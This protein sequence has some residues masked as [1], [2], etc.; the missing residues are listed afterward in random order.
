V[1][2]A[3][4]IG[5]KSFQPRPERTPAHQ[6]AQTL[7]ETTA[8]RNGVTASR[9][10]GAIGG[11]GVLGCFLGETTTTDETAITIPSQRSH[12]VLMEC[13]AFL[14]TIPGEKLSEDTVF[15]LVRVA[16]YLRQSQLVSNSKTPQRF[17][18]SRWQSMRFGHAMRQQSV[19]AS[20]FCLIVRPVLST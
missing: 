2:I 10:S 17:E 14:K 15:R 3:T 19:F 11:D 20:I 1:T 16:D 13:K 12:A 5:R 6:D 9:P 4:T 8:R 7:P 18:I